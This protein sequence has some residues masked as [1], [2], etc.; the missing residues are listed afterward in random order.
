MEIL[1]LVVGGIVVWLFVSQTQ[2]TPAG[3]PPTISVPPSG[4]VSPSPSPQVQ[5]LNPVSGSSN[6][7]SVPG[8][9]QTPITP[10][11]ASPQSQILYSGIRTPVYIP[12]PVRPVTSG[13][14]TIV[15]HP[16]AGIGY[17]VV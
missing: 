4:A 16:V 12:P 10:Q 13:G 1:A 5:A 2:N 7:P 14:A 17:R 6:I 3:T 11:V 15:P 8:S 9:N